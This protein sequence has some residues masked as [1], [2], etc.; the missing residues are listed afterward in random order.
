[1][2]RV[3]LNMVYEDVLAKQLMMLSAIAW[4]SSTVMNNEWKHVGQY[5]TSAGVHMWRP[6]LRW[7]GLGWAG[8]AVMSCHS[9]DTGQYRAPC[10]CHVS[11][12]QCAT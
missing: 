1:M 2:L 6:W 5:S 7:A 4:V 11:S 8:D 12:L 9:R 3:S 10:T